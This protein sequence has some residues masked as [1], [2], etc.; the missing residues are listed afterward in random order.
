MLY[1]V[2]T[3]GNVHI[4]TDE[5]QTNWNGIIGKIQLE[6]TTKTYIS[7]LRI[8]PDIDNKKALI[9]LK[10]E[11]QPKGKLQIELQVKKT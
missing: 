3:Y 4:Y 9:D 2:I 7:D 8:K 1:E 11:N 10:I 6:A 5:T